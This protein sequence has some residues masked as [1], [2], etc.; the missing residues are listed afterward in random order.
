M[1]EEAFR[2]KDATWAAL[3]LSRRGL[4]QGQETIKKLS[5]N[6][7]LTLYQ[8]NGVPTLENPS[9]SPGLRFGR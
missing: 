8:T 2:C 9:S 6:T 7:Y 4:A 5:V 3:D 1:V